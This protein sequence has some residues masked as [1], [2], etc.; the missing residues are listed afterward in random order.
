MNELQFDYNPLTPVPQGGGSK[1]PWGQVILGVGLFA[2]IITT[3]WYLTKDQE[4]EELF[5]LP[6]E[7]DNEDL[8]N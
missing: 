3:I 5:E 2:L 8:E 7:V 1:F 6:E 4:P